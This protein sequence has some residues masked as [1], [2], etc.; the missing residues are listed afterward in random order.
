MVDSLDGNDPI[1][2]VLVKAVPHGVSGIGGDQEYFLVRVPF[3]ENQSA[4]DGR[5]R[6]PNAPLPSKEDKPQIFFQE[7][8]QLVRHLLFFPGGLIHHRS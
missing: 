8:G 5:S 4:G 2:D 6:F 1:A 7:T 3:G